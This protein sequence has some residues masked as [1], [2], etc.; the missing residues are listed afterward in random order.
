M[1]KPIRCIALTAAALLT[2]TLCQPAQAQFL[3]NLAKD[4]TNAVVNELTNDKKS[5]KNEKTNDKSAKSKTRTVDDAAWKEWKPTPPTPYIT[6]QTKFMHLDNIYGNVVSD[7]NS[8]IFAVKRNNK[9]EFWRIDGKKLFDPDWTMASPSYQGRDFPE[10][11]D[12]VAVARRATPNAQGKNIICLLYA[13][14]AV[15]ELDPSYEW[16][17]PFMDGVALARVNLGNYKT[18]HVFINTKGEKIY[19]SLDVDDDYTG[20]IHPLRD[21]LRAYRSGNGKFGYIND[22]GQI[23]IQPKYRT[24]RNFSEGYAW[25]T[26]GDSYSDR[27]NLLIDPK[28]QVVFT[29]PDTS[30]DVSS[31]YYGDVHDGRFKIINDHKICYYNPKGEKLAEFEDGNNFYGGNAFVRANP[32]LFDISLTLVDPDFNKLRHISDKIMTVNSLEDTPTSIFEPYGLASL[33]HVIN[34]RG[35]VVIAPYSDVKINTYAEQFGRFSADGY[36]LIKHF[37]YGGKNY[38]GLMRP[39][40]HI[41][42]LFS[43]DGDGTFDRYPTPLPIDTVRAGFNDPRPEPFLIGDMPPIGPTNTIAQKYNVTVEASPAEGGTVSLAAAGPFLY[44][45]HTSFTASA[46]EGWEIAGIEC[47]SELARTPAP[48]KS[49]AVIDDMK[50]TVHFY[51]EPEIDTPVDNGAYQQQIT[52]LMNNEFEMPITYYAEISDKPDI[53][54][55]YGTGTYGFIVPMIDPDLKILGKGV[56][57]YFLF[58][59]MKITGYQKESDGREYWTLTGG[60]FMAHDVKVDNANPLAALYFNTILGINGYD[61][62]ELEGMLYR[63]EIKHNDD[64]SISLGQLEAFSTTTGGW[65][66]GGS[67]V[68]KK[69]QKGFM[70]SSSS[71]SLPNDLFSGATLR[72][73]PKRTDILWYP[74]QTW[75]DKKG[76]LDTLIESLTTLYRTTN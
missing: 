25:V 31:K 65:V 61:N 18:K 62:P 24:A 33:S 7:V 39:D 48:G 14:G 12:G 2:A 74:P 38:I 5:T 56:S 54:T 47:D 37:Q 30:Y 53:S 19:P 32:E 22:G 73:A 27:K 63:L 51:K 72:A 34:P 57:A 1:R 26:E 40:A 29:S 20:N 68:L 3:K 15:R 41:D 64:G 10:F 23:V 69:T 75:Y 17:T 42:W 44:G 76:A 70:A 46:R 67:K 13:N 35:E 52:Q 11:I 6:S 45:D 58:L 21:G 4:L 9:Y 50:I 36:A 8:G 60:K 66:P 28:G 71:T 55:P 43:A 49:F 59:P 16:V